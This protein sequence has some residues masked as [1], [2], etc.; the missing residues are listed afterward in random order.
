MADPA[1]IFIMKQIFEAVP[2]SVEE[3]ARIDGASTLRTFWYVVLPMARPALIAITILSV[4]SAWNEFSHFLVVTKGT[5]EHQT[6]VTRP[7]RA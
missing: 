1:G 4:Q 3:A 7:R 6:L 2:A 5:P